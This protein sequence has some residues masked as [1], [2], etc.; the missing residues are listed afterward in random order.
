MPC[1]FPAC[2]PLRLLP[3]C[4]R[5]LEQSEGAPS[6]QAVIECGRAGR[7]HSICAGLE[8][9]P[10]HPVPLLFAGLP[11]PLGAIAPR[12]DSASVPS[13]PF[14]VPWQLR[15]GRLVDFAAEHN[16]AIHDQITLTSRQAGYMIQDTTSDGQES[17][18]RYTRRQARSLKKGLLACLAATRP[19]APCRAHTEI[20][21]KQEVDK[22]C[23][24]SDT[25]GAIRNALF[26]RRVLTR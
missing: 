7:S 26:H 10:S 18:C 15:H 3:G 20:R 2:L 1:D 9:A 25:A 23:V 6:A 17:R 12:P 4:E 21:D 5:C 13:P 11:R 24:K 8:S 22:A 16:L 14:R 19:D